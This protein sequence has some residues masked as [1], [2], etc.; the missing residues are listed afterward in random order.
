MSQFYSYID[1]ALDKVLL[2]SDG[3]SLTGFYFNQEK[4]LPMPQSDWHH[5]PDLE[6]FAHTKSQLDE[7]IAG[8]RHK[9]TVNFS[10]A[11]GTSFQQKVWEAL[12]NIPYGTTMSY[13]E[14]AKKI[15]LPKSVRAVA[16]AV[17]KNPISL[18]VPCHRVIG[19]NG[20][21]TGFAGGLPLKQAILKLE[22]IH[23]NRQQEIYVL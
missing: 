10:F 22:G 18:I 19:S 2:L 12:T 14:L 6:V 21:L 23:I 9:F 1:N 8:K 20:S 17:G 3:Q 15:N 4:Y 5:Q 11:Q 7:Y 16:A 13:L